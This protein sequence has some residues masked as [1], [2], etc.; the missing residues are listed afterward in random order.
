MAESTLGY[1]NPGLLVETHW[2]A[3]HLSD[4]DIRI[5][6]C[7]ARDSYTRAH[8]PGAVCPRDSWMKDPSDPQRVLVTGPD[9]FAKEMAGLGVG[10]DTLVIAYDGLRSNNAA[11]LW[12]V[13]NY[14]GHGNTKVLNGGWNKWLA[15]GRPVTFKEPKVP[16][17]EFT[18]TV[19]DAIVCK[20][21]DLKAKIGQ[22]GVTIWDVRSPEEYDGRNDRGNQRKGHVPGAVHAEWTAMM[23]ADDLQTFKPA[24]EMW[25]VLNSL[26]ITPEAEVVT[27]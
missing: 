7:G 10:D 8:I 11:R 17:A 1:A 16:A 15:E 4:P 13:L 18:P 26:G 20:V 21:D 6:D 9:A 12:W 27:Y 2:L 25:A 5:V 14:Y 24:A 22:P 19:V 23:S 3:Q